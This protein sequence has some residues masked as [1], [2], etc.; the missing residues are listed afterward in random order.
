[1]DPATSLTEVQVCNHALALIGHSRIQALDERT[2]TAQECRDRLPV[3]LLAV[4][5]AFP[6]SWTRKQILLSQV[7]TEAPVPWLYVYSVPS[8]SMALE[9]VVD[10]EGCRVEWVLGA[11][12]ILCNYTP[13][14]L[15]YNK[16]V[17]ID[18]LPADA[19]SAVAMHLAWTLTSVLKDTNPMAKAQLRR[20]FEKEMLNARFR[21]AS[22]SGDRDAFY[23]DWADSRFVVNRNERRG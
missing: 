21:S 16:H 3:S 12:G 13:V 1:M 9:S 5:R 6:W 2:P 11:E 15:N 19:A 7:N 22:D 4:L 20:D 18:E 17:P 14:Y 23:L 8:D 10:E